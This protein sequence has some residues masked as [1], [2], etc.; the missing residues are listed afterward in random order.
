MTYLAYSNSPYVV[1]PDL[2]EAFRYTWDKFAHPGTW[3]S[4]EERIAV[5]LRKHA[6]GMPGFPR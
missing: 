6:P 4:G 5:D 2:R 1:R 3:L